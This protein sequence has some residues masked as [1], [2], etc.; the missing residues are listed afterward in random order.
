M[1]VALADS[2]A[3]QT[4]PEPRESEPDAGAT[5]GCLIRLLRPIMPIL[6]LLLV[7]GALQYLNAARAASIEAIRFGVLDHATRVTSSGVENGIDLNFELLFAPAILPF[8]VPG[9]PYV[10]LGTSFNGAGHNTDQIYTGLVWEWNM[11]KRI[12]A[13]FGGGLALHNGQRYYD[14]PQQRAFGQRVL[15]RASFELGRRFGRHH[16]LA[17]VYDH[18]SNGPMGGPNEG[19]DNLGL[20][21]SYRF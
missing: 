16:A 19:L 2:T 6:V 21:Y 15:F 11:T 13:R 20:R 17:I 3:T 4:H 1:P 7:I 9:S 8:H 14:S 12:F 18:I 5:S 10:N